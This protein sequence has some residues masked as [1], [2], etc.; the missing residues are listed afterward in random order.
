MSRYRAKHTDPIAIFDVTRPLNSIERGIDGWELALQHLFGESGFGLQVN[1]TIVNSDATFDPTTLS[2][3]GVLIG[4]SDS[5]NL[6][7]FFENDLFS[8]RVAANWRDRFLFAENQLR[9]TNEPVY[10]D[11][12]LQVDLSASWFITDNITLSF[13]A[14]NLTGEDQLQTGR[15]D[16]QFLLENDQDP[17]YALGIRARW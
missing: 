9:A 14:L 8:I 16:E 11:E 17:R 7:P 6:V 4:L 3:Q 10:F 13:D 12:Y 1:Y 2:Q 15:Y 5:W